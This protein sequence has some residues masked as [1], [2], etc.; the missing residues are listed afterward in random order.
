MIGW[1]DAIGEYFVGTQTKKRYIGQ[2]AF[3]HEEMLNLEELSDAL[4]NSHCRES[5]EIGCGRIIPNMVDLYAIA[6]SIIDQQP[7]YLTLAAAESIR[8]FHLIAGI[9]FKKRDRQEREDIKALEKRQELT[10]RLLTVDDN[11][12]I[13]NL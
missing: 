4:F 7:Y 1:I 13:D 12:W 5:I 2:R 9:Y 11:S 6:S 10:G 8:I 3:Y